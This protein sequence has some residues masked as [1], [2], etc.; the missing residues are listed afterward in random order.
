MKQP[1]Y[2]CPDREFGC[3]GRCE[4]YVKYKAEMEIIKAKRK[5]ESDVVDTIMEARNRRHK[6]F[7]NRG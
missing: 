1:C 6:Y 7:W 2:Q 5:E 4:R 3:H